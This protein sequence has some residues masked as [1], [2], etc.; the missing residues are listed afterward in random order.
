MLGQKN[1]R[2]TASIVLLLPKCHARPLA[3]ISQTRKSLKDVLE[4]H[5]LRHLN[6]YPSWIRKSSISRMLSLLNKIKS[7]L[8]IKAW[9]VLSF[10]SFKSYYFSTHFRKE[11]WTTTECIGNLI[12]NSSFMSNGVSVILQKVYPSPCLAFNLLWVD[13]PKGFMVWKDDEFL[14]KQVMLPIAKSLYYHV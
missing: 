4:T 8:K 12:F 10:N 13:I 9:C 5:N 2:S 1:R 11:K 7:I 3:W 14:W 6:K